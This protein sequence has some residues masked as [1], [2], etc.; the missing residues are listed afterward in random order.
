MERAVGKPLRNF[1]R[2]RV[3]LN[4]GG[5]DHGRNGIHFQGILE[6]LRWFLAKQYGGKSGSAALK[7]CCGSGG[8]TRL[9]MQ[10]DSSF[11]T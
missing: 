2:I 4:R 5:Q 11:G 8:F 9:P 3:F 6:V 10:R 7:N 1:S